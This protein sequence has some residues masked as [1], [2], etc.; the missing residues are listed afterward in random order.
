MLSSLFSDCNDPV[1]IPCT[2][3]S[4]I[5]NNE[6]Q[7]HTVWCRCHVSY[8]KARLRANI[9][10]QSQEVILNKCACLIH[11]NEFPYKIEELVV[12]HVILLLMIL[13]PFFLVITFFSIVILHALNNISCRTWGKHT[14]GMVRFKVLTEKC[15][16]HLYCSV[17]EAVFSSNWISCL[18]NV[19]IYI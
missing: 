8:H 12:V 1:Q 2:L 3:W 10:G 13:L 4:S 19:N 14:E 16:I 18:K 11:L 7:V 9:Q 5:R 17:S 6:Q 15:L